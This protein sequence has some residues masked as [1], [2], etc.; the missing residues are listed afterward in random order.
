VFANIQHLQSK[1]H[2][3]TFKRFHFSD[4]YS[5][6]RN[7]S[8]F[9]QLSYSRRNKPCF[10]DEI[11]AY[12]Q[13]ACEYPVL[14][15]SSPWLRNILYHP[16]I[17]KPRAKVCRGFQMGMVHRVIC[18]VSFLFDKLGIRFRILLASFIP[19]SGCF[20]VPESARIRHAALA[21]AER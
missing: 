2:H 20:T 19:S 4:L 13:F 6:M 7:P 21:G 10:T 11:S 3:K 9:I 14:P 8:T 1:T 15:I 12:C 5:A 18:R 16:S 17:V